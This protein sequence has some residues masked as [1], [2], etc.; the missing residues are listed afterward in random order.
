MKTLLFQG[1]SIT[2]CGRDREN[3]HFNGRGYIQLL[4]CKLGMDHVVDPW[5]IHNRGI[6]GNR[7]KDLL[8]RWDKDCIDLQP[9]LLSLYI[10]INNTWRR[11]D[12]DDPTSADVFEEELFSLLQQVKDQ[13]ACDFSASILLEPFVL[14]VPVG[15]KLHWMED[16][17]PKQA[18]VKKAAES[19]G[20]RHLPLQQ[21]FNQASET[22]PAERWAGDGVHPTPAGHALIAHHWLE[23][24][25]DVVTP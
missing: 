7:T 8:A 19:F 11:Y 18:I 1:D 5:T 24:M 13:T 3:N 17:A 10:G 21:I 14:D 20:M 15:K 22:A 4:T 23:A 2:D 25:N 9:D 16:L 12:K 6:S